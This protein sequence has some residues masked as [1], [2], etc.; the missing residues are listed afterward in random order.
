MQRC[1]TGIG[2]HHVEQ[3]CDSLTCFIGI[4]ISNQDDRAQRQNPSEPPD[5]IADLDGAAT[6]AEIGQTDELRLGLGE[7]CDVASLKRVGPRQIG[8]Q[9]PLCQ[10]SLAGLVGPAGLAPCAWRELAAMNVVSRRRRM[11]PR[12]S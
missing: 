3:F 10:Q 9:P 8:F 11:A 1:R 5:Q 4:P 7:L 2:V 12:P 6:E